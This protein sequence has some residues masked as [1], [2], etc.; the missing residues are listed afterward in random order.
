MTGRDLSSRIVSRFPAFSSTLRDGVLREKRSAMIFLSAILCLS[1]LIIP[2]VI[3]AKSSRKEAE[4]LKTKLRELSSLGSEY[5]SLK[6]RVV[7]LEQRKSLSK[8]TGVPQA[9]DDL[10]SSVGLKTKVKGVKAIGTREITGGTEESAEVQIEKVTTNEL[11]NL[12]FKIEDAPMMLSIKRVSMKKTFENPELLNVT[13][14]LSL[15]MK[16]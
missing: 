11:I 10:S 3:M 6:D 4:D 12:F 1:V 16:K 14:T 9:V 5:R 7:S 2:L 8:V 15:F 13:L